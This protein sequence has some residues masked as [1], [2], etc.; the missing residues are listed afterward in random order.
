MAYGNIQREGYDDRW[1]YDP[2]YDSS[3]DDE[4]AHPRDP[5]G[6]EY[7]RRSVHSEQS[8][9]S[10]H[11]SHSQQSRRSSFSS[12]SQQSQVYR[13]QQDLVTAGYEA[14]SQPAAPADYSYG[15]YTDNVGG[16]QGFT[17]YQYPAETGWQSVEQGITRNSFEGKKVVELEYEAYIPMAQSEMKKICW[18]VR[19]KWPSVKHIAIHHRL[20]VVPVSE[21][22]VIIAI[23]SPHRSE[24]L[25]AVKYCI[26]TLKATVPIWKKVSVC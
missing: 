17:D 20:G 18:D 16:H 8:A 24:S 23:S 12:R 4:N 15:Q 21:A 1:Q 14:P 22:S 25:E 2:R 6:D 5:Y 10:V 9:H 3:F 13:S 7:D 26:D 19:R 11:S